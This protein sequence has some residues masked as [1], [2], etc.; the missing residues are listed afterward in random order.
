M[1]A[2]LLR[3]A[4]RDGSADVIS[5]RGERRALALAKLFPHAGITRLFTSSARRTQLTVTPLADVIGISPEILADADSSTVLLS[6][7]DEEL[8][9]V[10]GHSNTVPPLVENLGGDRLPGDGIDR[11]EGFLLDHEYQWLYVVARPRGSLH[12]ATLHL[13]YGEEP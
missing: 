2:I 3:H 5:E 6:L 12:A 7:P 11:P 1:R 9:L 8:A 10:V 13:Q 4:D